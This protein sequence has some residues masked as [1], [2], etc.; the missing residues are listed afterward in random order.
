MSVRSHSLSLDRSKLCDLVGIDR[1]KHIRWTQ[2]GLLEAKTSYDEKDLVRAA[3]LDELTRV[4]KPLLAQAAWRQIERDLDLTG[5]RLDVILST[6]T[7]RARLVRSAHDL[8][9]L[10]PRNSPIVIVE[11]APRIG[12]VREKLRE[13]LANTSGARSAAATAARRDSGEAAEIIG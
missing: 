2:A 7:R 10:A 12:G 8:D 13:F 6:D 9:R 5:A 11:L 4:A 1:G 3:A